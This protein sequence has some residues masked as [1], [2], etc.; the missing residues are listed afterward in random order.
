M[1]GLGHLY[2]WMQYLITFERWNKCYRETFLSNTKLMPPL[3]ELGNVN[4]MEI[5]KI[6][7]FSC[8]V[9]LLD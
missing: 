5:L 6:I 3:L 2:Q 8:F 9:T 1:V 7:H 4:I